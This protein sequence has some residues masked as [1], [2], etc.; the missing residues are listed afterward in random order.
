MKSIST[1]EILLTMKD[2]LLNLLVKILQVYSANHW[3][4]FYIEDEAVKIGNQFGR[5]IKLEI[6]GRFMF[7]GG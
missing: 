5:D 3:N 6:E 7:S 2:M 1:K 4:K